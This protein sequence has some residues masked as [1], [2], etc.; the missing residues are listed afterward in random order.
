VR[1]V[2]LLG[3]RGLRLRAMVPE[4]PRERMRGLIGRAGFGHSEALLLEHTRSVHT[5]GMGFPISAALLDAGH[6]VRA[7]HRMP[8]GRL[9]LPRRGVRHVLELGLD[10]DVRPGDRITRSRS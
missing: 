10:A 2:T 1:T 5:F 7:V 3:P 4:G 9:L 8:P 6:V